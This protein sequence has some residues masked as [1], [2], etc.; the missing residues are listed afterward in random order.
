MSK[1]NFY[2]RILNKSLT[3][4]DIILFFFLL[5]TVHAFAQSTST[6]LPPTI[7]SSPTVAA[8]E[9]YGNYPINYNTGTVS[10][11]AELYKFSLGKG[12]SLDI[13]L[14]YHPSGIKV[15]DVSGQVGTG[16]SLFTGGCIS[17]EIRGIKDENPSGFYNFIKTHKGYV[18]PQNIDQITNKATLDSIAKPILDSSPDI[19]SLNVP[20]LNY[21]FFIGNDGEFHTIPYSNIKFISHPLSDRSGSIGKWEIVN[22]S[23]V[24]YNFSLVEIVNASGGL[25][26]YVSTWWL[27]SIVSPEG[28]TLATFEYKA[29]NPVYNSL[30]H[31]TQAFETSSTS[32]FP[33]NLKTPYLA[34]KVTYSQAVT[35]EALDLYRIS[36][37]GKGYVIFEASTNRSDQVWKLISEIKCYNTKDVLENKYTLSYSNEGI[38]PFLSQISKTGSDGVTVKYRTFT[39]YPGLP[40]LNSK[41][42]DSWGYYNGA[43]NTTLYP[44]D[45]QL[46]TRPYVSADRYPNEK[47]V[48]GTLKEIIYPSGGKT[49]FEFENNKKY[50]SDKVYTTQK[51]TFSH[52]QTDYGTV[53]SASFSTIAQKV[54]M[55]IEMAI[56]PASLYSVDISLVK[57]DDNSTILH[58]TNVSVPGNGFVNMGTDSNG[59]QRFV[60]TLTS[61]SLKAGTYKW[62]TQIITDDDR[63][64]AKKPSP[65]IISNDYYKI[66]TSTGTF[67]KIVGGLRI[68]QI[69]NFDSDGKLIGKTHYSYLDKNGKSSGVGAPEPEFVRAYAITE[70]VNIIS[71]PIAFHMHLLEIGETN[72]CRYNGSAMQYLYVTEEKLNG[73][74]EAL[75]TDY[76]YQVRDYSQN[77]LPHPNGH[78][79]VPYSLN[80]YK[81]GILLSKTEYQLKNNSY[82]PIR[83][84]YNTYK[85]IEQKADVP[86]FTALEVNKYYLDSDHAPE[87]DYKYQVGTYD[88]KAAKVYLSSKKTENITENGTVTD[89]MDY[90]YENPTY[91][92]LTSSKQTGS[93]GLVYESS[94]KYCFDE[95]T[96]ITNEMKNRN[97]LSFPLHTINKVNN[98]QVKQ[99][100]ILFDL[101]SS[102]L[103]EI[104]TMR[105]QS[106]ASA[107]YSEL[108]YHNYDSYGNPVYLSK[109]GS[110]QTF[111]LWSY[112]GQY[113]IAEIKNA[114]YSYTELETIVENVFSVASLNALS[115]LSTPNETKLKDG[116]LQTAL[117]NA[118]VTTYT[119]KP[120][121]GMLSS[122]NPSGITTYYDYDSFGRLKETYIYK[123]NIV[124]TAN[125]QT[126]QKY[127]YHYQNQ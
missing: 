50:G 70:M 91:Q 21:K 77:A 103:V 10:I 101:F 11:S 38:R 115:T 13:S 117:P 20:G 111:Y 16:W 89:I 127:D 124:S 26:E 23:G 94:Y 53:T 48:A 45:A 84:E 80:D 93:N 90:Y 25:T 39:Y 68:A 24:H 78:V 60:C 3:L 51:E 49:L 22:E 73:S 30:S 86:F 79:F 40:G 43:N 14:N 63:Q 5:I 41:A 85:V 17:R 76:E 87:Y 56:H 106:V 123:D 36:I 42:Q 95:N 64:S 27:Q 107:P 55:K 9:K 62:I 110:N 121:V 72:L 108:N 82:I 52:S 96:T 83:K 67:E 8:L 118:L 28:I 102:N 54:N 61:Y 15:E 71:T 75:K 105:E 31:T 69:S 65:I 92:Q 88:F 74:S 47:A 19:F 66:V 98:N 109:D 81:E 6:T 37:P 33:D 4:K 113:P 119:Y 57:V 99:V 44:F 125:K 100:D 59:M 97:M 126:I 18:F 114:L 35:Y 46:S 120:L 1:Y 58:Y 32:G 104:K 112:S 2:I 122:T 116:S 12:V 7:P 29:S 34:E